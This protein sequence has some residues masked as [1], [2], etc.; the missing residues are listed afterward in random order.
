MEIA[1]LAGVFFAVLIAFAASL[2]PAVAQ[3][4]GAQ[5][6][7]LI[8]SGLIEGTALQSGVEAYLGIPYAAAPVHELRWR[9]P[10][11]PASWDGLRPADTFAPQCI[12]PLRN[13]NANQYSGAETISEDCLYLNVWTLAKR[14]NAPVVVFIHGGAFFVGSGS[15]GIYEGEGVASQGAVFVNFNYRLGPLGFLALP[16]LS[17]ESSDGSS[18]N[19]GLLDQIAA[20]RWV[21][22]NIE[23][24]GGD[25]GNV[26][27]VGQSAGS[28]SVLALQASPLAKGLFHRAVGMS[29]AM[30]GGPIR[31]PSLQKAEQDGTKLMAVWK[32]QDLAQLRA[33]PADRL[34]VPRVPGGPT[35]GPAIDGRVLSAPI[36]ELFVRKMHSDVPLILG[37]T[38]DEALGGMGAVSGLAD[39]REKAKAQFGSKAERLLLLYPAHTDAEA[40]TQARAADRDGTVAVSMM[41]WASLQSTYGSAPIYSYE[42]ARPHSYAEGVKFSDL[43]PATAGAY[44]TSEVPFWLGTLEAFNRFRQTRNWS[45]A[46]REMSQAMVR[47]LVEFART[48]MPVLPKMAWPKLTQSRPRLVEFSDSVVQKPWPELKKLDFFK[49]LYSNFAEGS[50]QGN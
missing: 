42:F 17:A 49:D 8:E 25:P 4:G 22:R 37:F 46:D 27:I 34:V 21:Q 6:Q 23:K 31:I 33:M 41:N 29:G 47:A 18:G 24:F 3:A 12:Q 2:S 45:D 20:L 30:I 39:Y 16:E 1:K 19:Y 7:I 38:R 43:E 35:T 50:V 10:V 15:T 48:G 9:E 44:H 14:K 40:I 28:M 11:P 36:P 32:A 26:T 5:H 13:S